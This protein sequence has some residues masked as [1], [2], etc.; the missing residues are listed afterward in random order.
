[1]VGALLLIVSGVV[2]AFFAAQSIESETVSIKGPTYRRDKHP[3][4][5]WFGV[6]AYGLMGGIGILSGVFSLAT[7]LLSNWS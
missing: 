3:R 7:S 5:F 6:G 4:M 1:M 2:L